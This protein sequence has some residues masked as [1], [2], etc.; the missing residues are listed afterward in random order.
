MTAPATHILCIVAARP[1]LMKM[2]PILRALARYAPAI[3]TTLVHT[4]QHYDAAM[5]AQ[6]FA[7][8]DLPQPGTNLEVGSASHAR[9]T[10]EVMLRFEPV[11]QAARPDAVLVVGDVNSTLACAL[12]AA[13]EHIPVLHVEAG[14][15]SGDRSMPEE[16]NRI[17]TDQLSTLLFTSE[18]AGQYNLA[19]EGI[20]GER[21]HFSGNVMIDTLCHELP[22]AVP[23]AATVAKADQGGFGQSAAGFGLVTLHRPSNVDDAATLRADDPVALK[24]WLSSNGYDLS[25]KGAAAIDQYVGST[26]F[27]VALKLQ[28]NRTVG[29]LRPIVLSFEGSRPCIPLRL[30]AIAAQPDMPIVAYVFG[31]ARAVPINYRHVLLNLARIDWLNGGSNYRE[32]ASAAV[33]E[34][35]GQAFLTEY[36]GDSKPIADAASAMPGERIDIALLATKQHPVDFLLELF[37]QGFPQADSAL[38]GL[39][40]KY[41]PM[42]ASLEAQGLNDRLFYSSIQTYRAEID[43]DPSRAPLDS[44]AFARELDQMIA[45][46]LRRAREIMRS[47]PYLTRLFTTLSAAEM[48]IDPELDFNADA[49]KVSNRIRAK[50]TPHCDGSSWSDRT[51]SI[52]LEDGRVF[53]SS[54]QSGPASTG[55]MA[56]RVEQF[57]TIGPPV[58]LSSSVQDQPSIGRGGPGCGCTQL[59]GAVPIAGA[60]FLLAALLGSARR[61]RLDHC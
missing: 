42:P 15:R 27:F 61:T 30:T 52:E 56:A 14:L 50:A 23:S 17:L 38:L 20:P 46:P 39:L 41:V 34:A 59:G 13:K 18:A 3:R 48:T 7:A 21:I 16:I 49:A 9:Q 32:V 1:N 57:G 36:A 55:P 37:S 43:S 11:L 19:L 44:V 4:G 58:V 51:V 45:A 35:G 8:L 24:A 12:V 47:Y 26:Y 53:Q 10:A 60:I 28:Q 22:R 5:D 2:A 31:A 40:R 25:P 54:F 33:D 6:H 29:E